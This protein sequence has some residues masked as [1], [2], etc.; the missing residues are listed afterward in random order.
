VVDRLL[1]D[2]LTFA[3]NLSATTTA[4]EAAE[5]VHWRLYLHHKWALRR[6]L[7]RRFMDLDHYPP[8]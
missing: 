7:W 5:F 6:R 2:T 1:A 8:S 3:E 4:E